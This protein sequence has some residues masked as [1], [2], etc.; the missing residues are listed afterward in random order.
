MARELLRFVVKLFVVGGWAPILV[1]ATH[2]V[3]SRLM[4]LYE[5]LPATDIPMHFA[6]GMSIA[7]FVSG[8]F[9]ALPREV[10]RSSRLV[11]LELILVVSLAATAAV[12]WEFAEFACD[13]AFGTNIQISIGNTMQD[14]GL[15][16]LGACAFGFV[17]VSTLRAGHG[18]FL[19]VANEWLSGRAA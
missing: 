2:V 12:L 7:F 1:F 4:N 3:A 6:G 11:V 10:V 19:A 13:R 5:L 9:R 16:L 17:R 15:G 14:L 8:C 18:E